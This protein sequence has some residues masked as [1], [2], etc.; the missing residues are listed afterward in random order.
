MSARDELAHQVKVLELKLEA[1][2]KGREL[3]ESDLK[4]VVGILAHQ[5]KVLRQIR[6]IANQYPHGGVCGVVRNFLKELGL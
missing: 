4:S 5:N 2:E 6:D 1:A 3:A